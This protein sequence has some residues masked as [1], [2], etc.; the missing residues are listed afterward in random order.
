MYVCLFVSLVTFGV[1]H[2]CNG[3]VVLQ[4]DRAND[5][6]FVTSLKEVRTGDFLFL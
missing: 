6:D 1:V 5:F 2:A 4:R 3:H